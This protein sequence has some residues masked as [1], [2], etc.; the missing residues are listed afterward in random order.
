MLRSIAR[1]NTT[2]DE[3]RTHRPDPDFRSGQDRVDLCRGVDEERKNQI[4]SC[5]N[6]ASNADNRKEEREPRKAYT[7]P[8]AGLSV[9]MMGFSPS[10]FRFLLIAATVCAAAVG[11]LLP[12]PLLLPP[13]PFAPEAVGEAAALAAAAAATAVAAAEAVVIAGAAAAVTVAGVTA[14]ASCRDCCILTVGAAPVPPVVS[15]TPPPVLFSSFVVVVVVV[16]VLRSGCGR[17]A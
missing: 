12:A 6:A 15:P 4:T 9:V 3:Q 11:E 10:F 8:T 16:A 2:Q 1:H 13:L 7:Y 17:A 5:C 14:G